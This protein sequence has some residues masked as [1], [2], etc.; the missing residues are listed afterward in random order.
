[1]EHS[2]PPDVLGGYVRVSALKNKT[3]SSLNLTN[4][5]AST[6]I[7]HRPTWPPSWFSRMTFV[8]GD[9]VPCSTFLMAI[10]DGVSVTYR[11]SGLFRTAGLDGQRRPMG[12]LGH[13]E[14]STIQGSQ[15]RCH[16]RRTR[17]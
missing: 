13:A 1:M 4:G 2:P 10:S 11:K 12:F 3:Y 6:T 7:L 5:S 16:R 15:R 17:F 9:N 14:S 8:F